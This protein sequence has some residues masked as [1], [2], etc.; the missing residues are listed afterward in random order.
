MA[1]LTVQPPY[2]PNRPTN[3]RD[4]NGIAHA[5]SANPAD[6][7]ADRSAAKKAW[8]MYVQDWK[9][10]HQ[11]GDSS[12]PAQFPTGTVIYP[13][14]SNSAPIQ[15]LSQGSNNHIG[16]GPGGTNILYV[17]VPLNQVSAIASASAWY[18]YEQANPGNSHSM[19][20]TGNDGGTTVYFNVGNYMGWQTDT[21][22][23]V[24]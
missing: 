12:G 20:Y 22:W 3:P 6:T 23:Y 15:I 17:T 4:P 10:A 13:D 24:S 11:V 19:T 18:V 14:D 7:K 21:Y 9:V 8:A 1:N 2:D 16:Q 5:V